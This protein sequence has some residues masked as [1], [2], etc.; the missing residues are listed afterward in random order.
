MTAKEKNSKRDS[1]NIWKLLTS[2]D[3]ISVTQGLELARLL[4]DEVSPLLDGL[5]INDRTG[6]ILRN[7][8]FE[9]TKNNQ[10]RLDAILLTLMSYALP[11]ST[12]SIV[13]KKVKTISWAVEFVPLTGAK[14][15]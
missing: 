7:A 9:G 6:E 3:V 5:S 4:P 10:K 12:G 2:K 8:R 1:A 14:K 13:R 15:H 11:G